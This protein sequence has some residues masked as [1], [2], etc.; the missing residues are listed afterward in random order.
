MRKKV[1]SWILFDFANSA[2]ALLIPALLFPLYFKEFLFR[3]SALGDLNWGIVTGSIMFLSAILAPIFGAASDVL[4][5]RGKY[6]RWALFISIVSTILLAIPI[7]SELRW[8]VVAI[9]L[10]SAVSFN[11]SISMYD[12]FLIDVTDRDKRGMISGLGWAIGYLGGL[13][14]LII[15]FPII[16]SGGP[17]ENTSGY[18]I[19]FAI[20]AGFFLV[21]SLPSVF[22]FKEKGKKCKDNAGGG[23]DFFVKIGFKGVLS[24]LK[25]I[26]SYKEAFKFLLVF[27]LITDGMTALY[28]FSAIFAR[29]TLQLS[30][31]KIL[32]MLVVVQL[33]S[34]P[35]TAIAG[36]LVDKFSS[37]KIMYILIC[38]WFLVLE[39]MSLATNSLHFYLVSVLFGL[40]LGPTQASYRAIF[41]DIIPP[42]KRAEFFGF[43]T[44]ANKVSASL[45]PIFFGIVSTITGSQ[46]IA[47]ASLSLFFIVALIILKHTKIE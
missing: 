8:M 10:L 31:G 9:Y 36:Y 30:T 4:N 34:V 37:K 3:S 22:T 40:T 19:A 33:V 29:E 17:V 6:F 23:I 35:A 2:Y 5:I 1:I 26:K 16:K 46:R 27:Y 38:L 39:M 32:F 20:T 18:R 43:N 47:V 45:A 25:Q 14:C 41:A 11:L 7:S 24:T 42:D 12:A 15:L 44:L 13:L 21:F 28:F